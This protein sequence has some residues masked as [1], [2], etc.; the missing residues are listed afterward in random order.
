M[1]T[2]SEVETFEHITDPNDTNGYRGSATLEF[3]TVT[4]EVDVI[5]HGHPEPIDGIYRWYGRIATNDQLSEHLSGRK[6][7]AQVHTPT[8]SA[9]AQIGEPDVWDRYR[10]IGKSHPPYRLPEIPATSR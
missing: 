9:Q 6:A 7:T 4:I 5:L 1:T 3:A 10:V 2:E 8:G